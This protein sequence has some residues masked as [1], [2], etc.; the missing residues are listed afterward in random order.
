MVLNWYIFTPLT[1]KK[2]SYFHCNADLKQNLFFDTVKLIE[3][4]T[5][6]VIEVSSNPCVGPFPRVKILSFINDIWWVI[7]HTKNNIFTKM[8]I[9]NEKKI[10]CELDPIPYPE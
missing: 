2:N 10:K 5:L 4:L 9:W 1:Y 8:K 6:V 7:I 3:C